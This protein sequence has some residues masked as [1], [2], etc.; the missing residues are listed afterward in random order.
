LEDQ[1]KLNTPKEVSWQGNLLDTSSSFHSQQRMAFMLNNRNIEDYIH[2][3]YYL[4]KNNLYKI[5]DTMHLERIHN[6][7]IEKQ[8]KNELYDYKI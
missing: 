4:A 5:H 8:L 6:D 7:K 3:D 2:D 1:Y